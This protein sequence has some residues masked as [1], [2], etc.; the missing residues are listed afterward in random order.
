MADAARQA[1]AAGDI[2][3]MIASAQAAADQRVR[4]TLIQ[5]AKTASYNLGANTWP[6]WGD[7]LDKLGRSEMTAGLDAAKTSLR[8]VGELGGDVNQQGNAHWLIGAQHLALGDD[9][10]AL[11]AFETAADCYRTAGTYEAILLAE[12]F[13]ALALADRD[14]ARM[15]FQRAVDALERKGSD[16]ARFFAEQLKTAEKVFSTR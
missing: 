15:E 10:T 5:L 6:G 2:A 16:D 9:A 11:A 13:R 3:A 8:L 4:T 7:H 1:Y 12:G 14:A